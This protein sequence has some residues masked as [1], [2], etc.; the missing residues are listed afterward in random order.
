MENLQQEISF[1]AKVRAMSAKEIIMAMVDGLKNPTTDEVQ[2]YTFGFQRETGECIG[3]A[4]TNA[5][6]R[7]AGKKFEYDGRGMRIPFSISENISFLLDFEQAIDSLRLGNVWQ[8]DMLARQMGIAV[9]VIDPHVELP[10]L[11][12]ENYLRKLQPYID[13]ANSQE[14]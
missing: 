7:I 6:C 9:I 2:M 3:C 13:L 14:A 4:A 5:I 8:Y 11:T 10:I 1:E 12:T